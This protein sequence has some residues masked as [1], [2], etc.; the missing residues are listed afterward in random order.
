MMLLI[1]QRR[2]AAAAALGA[3]LALLLVSAVMVVATIGLSA[4]WP[5]TGNAF[6][7]TAPPQP[8]AGAAAP[9]APVDTGACAAI[10][11]PAHQWCVGSPPPRALPANSGFSLAGCWPWAVLVVGAAGVCVAVRRRGL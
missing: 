11:G 8:A 5:Q 6:A 9:H 10:V 3:A 4:W 2:Q 1:R 7:A